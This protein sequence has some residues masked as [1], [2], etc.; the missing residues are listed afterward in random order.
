MKKRF[1]ALLFLFI[2]VTPL[3]KSLQ[4]HPPAT[5]THTGYQQPTVA[6]T[7]EVPDEHIREPVSRDKYR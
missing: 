5:R 7:A 4:F 2:T 3:A 6:D 1:Y